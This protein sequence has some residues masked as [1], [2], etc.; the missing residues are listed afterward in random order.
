MHSHQGLTGG[1]IPLG[2]RGVLRTKDGDHELYGDCMFIVPPGFLHLSR[3][4]PNTIMK[5]HIFYIG[6][7]EDIQAI[8]LK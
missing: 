6:E 1:Y 3:A 8:V 2:N 4:A 7:P 5:E